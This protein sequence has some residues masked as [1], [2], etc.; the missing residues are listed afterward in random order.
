MITTF[1]IGLT[2]SS[3]VD[4]P[5]LPQRNGNVSKI[6]NKRIVREDN[7]NNRYV[8]STGYQ[9]KDTTL[10]F[11]VLTPAQYADILQYCNNIYYYVELIDDTTN[12]II[13]GMYYLLCDDVDYSTINAGIRSNIKIELIQR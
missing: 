10:V 4:F 11:D 5:R 7:H 9:K 8:T 2:S 13:K 3:T 12:E 1:K 6:S